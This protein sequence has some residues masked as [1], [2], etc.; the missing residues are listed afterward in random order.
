MSLFGELL[1]APFRVVEGI[2]DVVADV[3]EEI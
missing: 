1:A 3:L 2:S